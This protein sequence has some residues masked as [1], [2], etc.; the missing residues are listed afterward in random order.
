M[1][2]E[3]LT[4]L[5]GPVGAELE[6]ITADVERRLVPVEAARVAVNRLEN[7]I[8]RLQHGRP[9]GTPRQLAAARRRLADATAVLER[10][11]TRFQADVDPRLAPL[12]PTI[13][14]VL[15]E[16]QADSAAASAGPDADMDRWLGPPGRVRSIIEAFRVD[17]VNGNHI[18][19]MSARTE[20]ARVSVTT[21]QRV[22]QAY[23]RLRPHIPA[24]QRLPSQ[25]SWGGDD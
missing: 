24:G 8:F 23:E 18:A 16:A 13:D 22:R 3:Q 15:R 9:V 5:A 7:E 10:L 2:S 6:R 14:R 11:A 12:R 21:Y 1:T 20:E 25:P 17:C 4:E 19:S